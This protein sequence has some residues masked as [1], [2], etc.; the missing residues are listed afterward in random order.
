MGKEINAIL[1]VQTILIWTYAKEAAR[2]YVYGR[3]GLL[4]DQVFLI[5]DIFILSEYFARV[6]D[7]WNFVY[8]KIKPSWMV[9]SPC[10][11]LMLGNHAPV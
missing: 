4:V 8:A 9:K 10:R 7:S 1:S 3:A 5:I 11:L 2:G 6:L